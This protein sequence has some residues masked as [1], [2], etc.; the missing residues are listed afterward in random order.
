MP[1]VTPHQSINE[2]DVRTALRILN[3][4]PLIDGHNDWPWNIRGWYSNDMRRTGFDLNS[5]SIGQTDIGRLTRGRV[6]A[7]FWSA[8]VPCPRDPA[9][10]GQETHGES[11]LEAVKKTLQQ[12]DLLHLMI[13]M[14][15][16]HFALA[17][18]AAEVLE[19]FSSGRIAC[20]IGVEGLH[21]IGNSFSCLRLYRS[22]GVRYVT[23]THNCSNPY[24]DSATAPSVHS[25]GLSEEGEMMVREMNRIGLMID[26]SHT[27]KTVQERVLGLSRAP[28]IF[29]H[30]SCYSLCPHLRN[31]SDNVLD[32]LKLNGGIIMICFL[33]ELVS[34]INGGEPSLQD[35]IDHIIYAGERI[36]YDH[37]GIGSDF[38]GMLKGPD[39]LDEVSDYP[40]LVA[41][42]VSRGVSPDNIKRVIGLNIL[43]VM[44]KVDSVSRTMMLDKS[45]LPEC[46]AVASPWT[47]EERGMMYQEGLR[48]ARR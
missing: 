41:G 4:V 9:L 22:L 6:G 5:V 2:E 27:S 35:V 46:D 1:Q 30:S 11:H 48:R 43:R 18:N 34:P 17:K 47:D 40:Q 19:V 44:E 45:H 32:S 37:V 14:Y 23:L 21:Q 10:T 31:V 33:R 29:S 13:Q 16:A 15:P 3:E 7:Q 42:L 25:R 20:M 8:F 26:L 38:D 36:G 28:V 12:I 39:G 24:A